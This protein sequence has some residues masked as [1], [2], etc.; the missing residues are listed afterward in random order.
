MTLAIKLIVPHMFLCCY[1]CIAIKLSID[2]VYRHIFKSMPCAVVRTFW[3]LFF[4][5]AKNVTKTF[6]Q[7]GGCEDLVRSCILRPYHSTWLTVET[8]DSGGRKTFFKHN[9]ATYLQGDVSLVM[10]HLSICLLI[11]DAN[12]VFNLMQCVVLFG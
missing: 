8:G 2:S 6:L 1:R 10:Q 12:T 7:V 9:H 5:S 11:S 4:S 3:M